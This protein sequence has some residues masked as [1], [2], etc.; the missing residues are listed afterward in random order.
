MSRAACFVSNSSP[1]E[2]AAAHPK[3]QQPKAIE[4]ESSGR[5]PLQTSMAGTPAT[6]PDL[7]ARR[8]SLQIRYSI[9]R[10]KKPESR[11]K[12]RFILCKI[13]VKG[14]RVDFCLQ[15]DLAP[16][17]HDSIQSTR[18]RLD[19]STFKQNMINFD[20]I[21]P[22]LTKLTT[23]LIIKTAFLLEKNQSTHYR[24]LI[25]QDLIPSS[26]FHQSNCSSTQSIIRI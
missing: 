24:V 11:I 2:L 7:L 3:V 15:N 21:Q 1:S 8:L 25:L 23:K 6:T 12:Q 14:Q 9:G 18:I 16:S 26:Q 13:S 22:N 20:R 10:A 19:A 17:I 5:S 4:I